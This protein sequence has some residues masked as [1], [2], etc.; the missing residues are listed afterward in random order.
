[1]IFLHGERPGRHVLQPLHLVDLD[2]CATTIVPLFPDAWW[3]ITT[4]PWNANVEED[5][6]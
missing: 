3:S 5:A 6:A 2:W 4:D 1:M